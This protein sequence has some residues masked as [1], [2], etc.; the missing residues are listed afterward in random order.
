MTQESLVAVR[1]WDLPVRIFHWAVLAAFVLQAVTG[2]LGGHW[3]GLHVYSGY[4]LLVLVAFRV[5]WGFW[6]ST[7]ARFSSFIAGPA[8]TWRFA[9]RLFS[10]QAVPQ[11][12]H[13]P[14]GGWSVVLMLASLA[15]QAASGLAAH[16]GVMT[17]GPLAKHVSIELSIALGTVHR[18][19]FWI[20]AVL[21]ALHVLAVAY[22]WFFKREDLL[23]PMFTG[24]KHVPPELL[25]ERREVPRGAALRRA[26]SREPSAAYF[27]PWH[28]GWIVLGVAVALVALVVSLP[29]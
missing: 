22:H 13:N 14:L 20:L 28:R 26:A 24:V 23:A 7:H 19:N 16:D 18:W 11:L 8:A 27:P 2:Y 25:R 4:A 15:V 21:V 1:V 17:G 9:R 10:R 12:G 6:G 29:G 3:M 5:L